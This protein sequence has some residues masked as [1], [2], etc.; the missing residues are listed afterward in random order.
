MTFN[1]LI[2]Q[3]NAQLTH[4]ATQVGNDV[5]SE[6]ITD[7]T[8]FDKGAGN[9]VNSPALPWT[10]SNI[11][12]EITGVVK[13]GFVAIWYKGPVL[14]KTSFTGANITM[15]SGFNVFN[16]LCRVMI[17]CDK[18]SGAFSVN[19]QTGFTGDFP[20]P[21]DVPAQMSIIGVSEPYLSAPAQMEITGIS[22]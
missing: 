16:E 6:N 2:D 7:I 4:F 1:E 18:T 21:I 3:I 11:P 13:G 5:T 19:I 14:S 8:K 17:D 10:S 12:L 22:N 20:I 15:I 9:Y